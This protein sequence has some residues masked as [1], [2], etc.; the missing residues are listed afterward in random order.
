MATSDGSVLLTYQS[1]MSSEC[2]EAPH[3]SRPASGFGGQKGVG[4]GNVQSPPLHCRFHFRGWEL[5]PLLFLKLL[6]IWRELSLGRNTHS[7]WPLSIRHCPL[8]PSH[9]NVNRLTGKI[10]FDNKNTEKTKTTIYG[11]WKLRRKKTEE[12]EGNWIYYERCYWDEKPW[13]AVTKA[14]T[15]A[16]TTR[17]TLIHA[18]TRG[19]TET[20]QYW[21]WRKNSKA[22][23]SGHQAKFSIARCYFPLAVPLQKKSSPV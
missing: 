2:Q 23:Y 10:L 6:K 20:T 8:V 7:H 5:R 22:Y 16:S 15:P 3:H 13:S 18:R 1:K 21:K 14:N 11:F 19:Y 12:E 9:S 4:P 17:Q